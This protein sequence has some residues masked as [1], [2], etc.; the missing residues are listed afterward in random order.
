[1]LQRLVRAL[2]RALLSTQARPR[3]RLRIA[4]VA[5]VLPLRAHRPMGTQD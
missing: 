1:M 4:F 2:V 5:P 3:R